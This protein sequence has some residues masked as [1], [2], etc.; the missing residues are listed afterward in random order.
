MVASGAAEPTVADVLTAATSRLRAAGIAGAPAEAQLLLTAALGMPK[1]AVLAHPERAIGGS[2]RDRFWALVARRARR[3]PFA[4]VVGEREFYGLTLLVDRRVLVPRPETELLVEQALARLADLR[5]RGVG[6]PLVVDVG[7]GSGAIACAVARHAPDARVVAVDRS[8]AAL[9]VAALNCRR[10][11]AAERVRLVQG[12]LLTW[13]GSRPDLVVA[14]LPYVP[15]ARLG[16]LMPEVSRFEPWGA[17]DGG[18][19]GTDAIRRLLDQARELVRPTAT[20]LLELDPDQVERVRAMVRSA[21]VEVLPDL[22]G[23]P[24]VLRVGPR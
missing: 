19:D 3:E 13:L 24:R 1:T 17:L 21:T 23:V 12:D 7:T 18:P 20:I 4:Y 10:L 16:A 5:A 6:R 11:E 14:N 9:R 2:E 8:A 22:A 15:T